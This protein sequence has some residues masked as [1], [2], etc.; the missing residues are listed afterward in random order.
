MW[1]KFKRGII[2]FTKVFSF[3][4]SQE[5]N[6]KQIVEA[7]GNMWSEWSFQNTEKTNKAASQEKEWVILWISSVFQLQIT[8]WSL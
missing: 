4:K 6:I 3:S 2:M 7:Y 8:H 5:Q 1:P